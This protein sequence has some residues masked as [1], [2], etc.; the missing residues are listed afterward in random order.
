MLRNQVP[1]KP[2]ALQDPCQGSTMEPG[3]KALFFCIV[4]PAPFTDKACQLVK[5]KS[6]KAQICFCKVGNKSWI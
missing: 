1:E 2:P 4:S 6:D 5:K 3:N